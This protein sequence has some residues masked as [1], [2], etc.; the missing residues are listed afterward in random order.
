MLLLDVVSHRGPGVLSIGAALLMQDRLPACSDVEVE[1]GVGSGL[2]DEGEGVV[3]QEAPSSQSSGRHRV[4]AVDLVHDTYQQPDDTDETKSIDLG[5]LSLAAES[6]TPQPLP[7]NRLWGQ[8]TSA[9]LSSD[10]GALHRRLRHYRTEL[11]NY[12]QESEKSLHYADKFRGLKRMAIGI[13]WPTVRAVA[14]RPLRDE[15]TRLIVDGLAVGV[16]D[17]QRR[18]IDAQQSAAHMALK[19]LGKL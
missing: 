8:S 6:I 19:Y 4:A 2:R 15:L 7:Q 18:L 13:L 16:G 17:P 1:S 10:G 9:S 12:C 5:T 3:P 14:Q 11:N